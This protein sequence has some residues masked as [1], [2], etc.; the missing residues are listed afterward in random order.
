MAIFFGG[1][2]PARPAGPV[3]G[4]QRVHMRFSLMETASV[5]IVVYDALG[6]EVERIN[7]DGHVGENDI[8]WSVE[9]Y[10]SGIYLCKL[11]A[12]TP[13]R[14]ASALVKMAVRQ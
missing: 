10:A 13:A 14:S 6:A 3:G 1:G 2:N 11:Q 12:K 4:G 8:A 5:E 9:T 7:A